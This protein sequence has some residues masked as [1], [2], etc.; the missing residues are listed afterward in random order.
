M[1]DK[2]GVKYTKLFWDKI[3]LV[4]TIYFAPCDI[5]GIIM[6]QETDDHVQRSF[7]SAKCDTK[8]TAVGQRDNRGIG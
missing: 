2:N 6:K 1:G 4:T 7:G 3:V 8:S 5:V